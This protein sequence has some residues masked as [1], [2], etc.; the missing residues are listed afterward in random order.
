MEASQ[1]G[2][3]PVAGMQSPRVETSD[4]TTA[5]DSDGAADADQE[6]V[7]P[8]IAK[9][10]E[11]E[12]AARSNASATGDL[13]MEHKSAPPRPKTLRDFLPYIFSGLGVL[14][15]YQLGR[16]GASTKT[17]THPHEEETATNS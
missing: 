6:E 15:S 9:A 16:G 4:A 5:A 11:A 14:I 3:W 1:H 13:G 8:E 7:D 17:P 12:A 2:S 10:R